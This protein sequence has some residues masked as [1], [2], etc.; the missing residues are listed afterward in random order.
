MSEDMYMSRVFS[1]RPS[2]MLNAGFYL[3]D[4]TTACRFYPMLDQY[5]NLHDI[6]LL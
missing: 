2:I 3:F 1:V 4:S 6:F 5:M